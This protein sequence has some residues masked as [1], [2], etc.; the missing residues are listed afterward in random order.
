MTRQKHESP[1]EILPEIRG[2]LIDL[3]GVLYTGNHA[4]EG[5]PETI[6]FLIDNG[7]PFRCVSNT[8]RKCRN[9][10][11]RHLASLGIPV[12]DNHTFTP[13][14]AAVTFMK[15]SGRTAFFLL[16]T[17]DVEK[18]FEDTGHRHTTA[19][20]DLVIIGDAGDRITYDSM[21]DAF[22]HLM[23]GADLIALE[24]DRYW[25]APDGLSLGAGPFVRGLEYA[26]GKTALVMGKPSPDFFGLALRDMGLHPD[27]VIMI[28]DDI[29]TDIGGAGGAGIRGIL[30]RTGK[31]RADSL[32]A[33]EI[34]PL[35]ILD[36]IAGLPELIRAR[37]G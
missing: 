16:T 13:A 8:T 19:R 11:A 29:L 3:D 6:Q 28:G 12:P 35:C 26:S 31:F 5:A 2:F 23:A 4:I 14:M 20:P 15:Q 24:C 36:T 37:H 7:Y 34:G 22:R 33:A 27:E 25:M 1:A 21:N 10:I 32:A 18:D 17:G 9:T 30:V